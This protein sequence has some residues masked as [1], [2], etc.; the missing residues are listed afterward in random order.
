M[1]ISKVIVVLIAV[2]LMSAATLGCNKDKKATAEK[3]DT[4]AKPAALKA[5]QPKAALPELAADKA[6]VPKVEAPKV[7]IAKAHP[8]ADV[9]PT[10]EAEK[11]V[12]ERAPVP[13]VNGAPAKAADAKAQEPK[14]S[15]DPKAE[16][17]SNPKDIEPSAKEA[18]EGPAHVGE[19]FTLPAIMRMSDM[20][21]SPEHYA[22]FDAVKVRAQVLAVDKGM[23]LVGFLQGEITYSLMTRVD[24]SLGLTVEVGDFL[25]VEG[26]LK[27]ETWDQGGLSGVEQAGNPETF[28]TSDSYLLEV[29]GAEHLDR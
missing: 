27:N 23:M 1:R 21:K 20:L 16:E 25:M 12:Q 24:P 6:L 22:T 11:V 10:L 5:K 17:A 2:C 8:T 29:A 13:T 28:K 4:P 15:D 7:E 3:K 14:D 19:E 26:K 9:K 18:P